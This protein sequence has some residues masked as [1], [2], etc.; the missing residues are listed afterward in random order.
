M[1]SF[2]GFLTETGGQIKRANEYLAEQRMKEIKKLKYNEP[3][4]FKNKANED[5]YNGELP[6]LYLLSIFSARLLGC[7]CLRSKLGLGQ[8]LA[9]PTCFPHCQRHQTHWALPR[10]QEPLF[11]TY[12]SQIFSGMFLLEMECIGIVLEGPKFPFQNQAFSFGGHSASSLFSAPQTSLLHSWA[13]PA[14]PCHVALYLQ[15]LIEESHS[16]CVVD[17]A[18]Y[19]I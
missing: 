17:S 19:G 11:L 1:D 14:S 13:C 15:H 4:K 2:K 5:H 18:V 12:G 16:P 7:L 9:W 6:R 8:Q 10:S 3:R